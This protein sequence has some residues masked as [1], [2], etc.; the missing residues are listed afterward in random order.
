MTLLPLQRGIYCLQESSAGGGSLGQRCF[1]TRDFRISH[2]E[3]MSP[4]L[5]FP[6]RGLT[7]LSHPGKTSRRV[8]AA[9]SIPY[10]SLNKTPKPALTSARGSSS[11]KI[12]L[13]NTRRHRNERQKDL[14]QSRH[15]RPPGPFDTPDTR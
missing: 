13:S 1:R 15:Q 9:K 8:P 5:W 11:E 2:I 14:S 12:R 3:D 4:A 7:R 6:F 10:K